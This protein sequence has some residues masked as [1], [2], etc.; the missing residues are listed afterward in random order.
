VQVLVVNYKSNYR[1]P[2][3]KVEP[4]IKLYCRVS[5]ID[6]DCENLELEISDDETIRLH[7]VAE[8]PGKKRRVAVETVPEN[9]YSAERTITLLSTSTVLITLQTTSVL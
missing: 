3:I 7:E 8:T 9:A 6:E 2:K 5:N 1:L 4:S